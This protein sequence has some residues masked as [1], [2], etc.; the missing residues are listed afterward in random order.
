MR[1]CQFII[2]AIAVT[3]TAVACGD[4]EQPGSGNETGNTGNGYYT[5]GNKIMTPDG[6]VASFNGINWYGFEDEVMAPHGLNRRSMDDYLDQ[7][8]ELGYNLI[9]LPYSN[10][11][12]RHKD[13]TPPVEQVDFDINP[14]MKGKMPIEWMDLFIEKA[15]FRGIHI[16][17]DRHRITADDQSD[18]W[19]K[20]GYSEELWIADWELLARRY[21]DNELVIGADLHN[22]P[23]GISGWG[24]DDDLRDW[25]SAAERCGNAILAVNPS[26]LIV[27]EGTEKNVVGETGW[28][29][30]GS[31]LK[32]VAE[33][34]IELDVPNKLVYSVHDYGPEMASD[35]MDWMMEDFPNKLVP[36]WD[37]YWGYVHKEGIAPVLVGE[38]GA[39]D[40]SPD[41]DSGIWFRELIDYIDENEMYWTFWTWTPDSADTRGLLQANWE[42]IETDKQSLLEKLY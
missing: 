3:G 32:G 31:N 29:W 9:R 18:V 4:D 38:F 26:W 24:I 34:P 33:Y 27:V 41:S 11:M 37:E 16:L 15:T 6:K 40:V 28:T 2:V 30:W 20:S 39:K 23:H 14:E 22:E 36:H 13:D 19:Y 42:D 25:R 7:I 21:H 1:Q 35:S 17:L 8:A 5:Q 12:L 10:E